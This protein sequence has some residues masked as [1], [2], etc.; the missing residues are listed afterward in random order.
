[1]KHH[2][3]LRYTNL[4]NGKRLMTRW[5]NLLLILA[6]LVSP[7]VELGAQSASQYV[8]DELGRLVAVVAPSGDAAVYSYDAVGNLL[9]ISRYTSSTV[10]VVE[11]TPNAG[12]TGS[13]VTIYG[14]GFSSTPSQNT[15][16]FNGVAATVV[17]SST[18][19]IVATVPTSATT[20][21][22]AVTSPNGSATSTSSFA[23]V[24]TALP[25]ITSFSPSIGAEGT[26]VTIT[27]TNF[28]SALTSNR[29][30]LNLTG[31]W[32]ST[33]SAT[34]LQVA[35]P[36][37]GG[38][39]KVSVRTPAGTAISSADFFVPP[40]PY[41]AADVLVTDR[42]AI[43]DTR[44][45]A[46]GTSSKVGLVIFDGTLAQ[47]V[48]LKVV[49]GPL[50]TVTMY[51]P[52]LRSTVSAG[53]G[54]TTAL[55]EPPLLAQTGTYS[56]LVD[57]TG[58]A[59]GTTT[60]TLYNVPADASGTITAGGSAVTVTTTV[61][62]QNGALT[63]TG[64]AGHRMALNVGAGPVGTVSLR[65]PDG[66]T[67]ASVVSG[68]LSAFMEPTTLPGSG[69]HSAFVD[70]LQA[71][72]G[73]IALT[74]Y[75]VPADVTGTVTVNGSATPVT[76][77][78]AGQ[79][80]SL[81]FSGTSG[82]LMT[83]SM[84]GNTMSTTTVKLLKPDGSQ[85]TASTSVLGSFNLAQ[86]TLPVTGTYTVVVDPSKANTGSINVAVTNP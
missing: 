33:G 73:S 26:A 68:A 39:G 18:T 60:L 35:V 71:N 19:T 75:D 43:G 44:T 32:P 45:V 54:V 37:A 46:I 48:S 74:L 22:I 23:V 84:T 14:T 76:I 3:A 34:S 59:T 24:A 64:T 55:L 81:T 67:L 41:V 29:V 4:R 27:G 8:Y 70:Y 1:M 69:T 86:Q 6:L 38:S 25:T 49:P 16:T 28:D 58:T 52:N 30:T 7:T 77:T 42:M 57:P 40:E 20:G 11:F 83:V 31:T 17:S 82:Q 56:I 51:R 63:F 12:P 13:S 53:I 21:A 65:Q 72:T 9:S 47:R 5:F 10:S 66:T 78:T 80:A 15:V 50:S 62:G 36:T 61:P 2:P 85:L 79:N